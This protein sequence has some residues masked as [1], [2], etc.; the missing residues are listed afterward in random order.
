MLGSRES[1]VASS[2]SLANSIQLWK[3]RI[4]REGLAS[5]LEGPIV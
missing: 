1:S 2:N 4:G 5:H 3:F